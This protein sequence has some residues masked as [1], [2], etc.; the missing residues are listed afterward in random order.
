MGPLFF[1]SS[2]R[3]KRSS[4]VSAGALQTGPSLLVMEEA[5]VLWQR[6][7]ELKRY[8]GCQAHCQGPLV[9]NTSQLKHG[10]LRVAEYC[11]GVT[12]SGLVLPLSLASSSASSPRGL[13][14]SL[15]H[16]FLLQCASL[17]IMLSK[18]Y[19]CTLQFLPKELPAPFS[20]ETT[21]SGGKALG[22]SASLVSVLGQVFPCF[23]S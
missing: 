6:L 4:P 17:T 19:E 1:S 5:G 2:S 8:I 18:C 10:R 22:A 16:P 14:Y 15:P 21:S 9:G 3:Q 12:H 13:S 7:Y 20:V 11:T 23:L